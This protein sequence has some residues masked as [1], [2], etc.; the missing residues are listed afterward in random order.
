MAK[1][2][3]DVAEGKKKRKKKKRKKETGSI[4]LCIQ[5]FGSAGSGG[6]REGGKTICGQQGLR[7]LPVHL[8]RKERDLVPGKGFS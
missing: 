6:G 8:E 4:L 2:S 7:T 5:C 1:L 3:A